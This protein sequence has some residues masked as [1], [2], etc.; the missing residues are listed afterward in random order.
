MIRTRPTT[1]GIEMRAARRC[2]SATLGLLAVPF[3]A[4]QGGPDELWNMTTRMEMAG[5]PGQS[6]SSQ[7]CMKKGQTQPDKMSQDKNCKATEM[8]TVG[9]KTTWKV[10]C[11]GREPMTGEGEVTRTRESMD[12][13]MRMQGK[14][15]N[16]T[17]DMTTVIS[18]RL[19]GACDAA[20]QSRQVQAAAAQGSAILAQQCKESMDK[21][22]TVMFD[23]QSAPCAAQ[24]AEYCGRVT[25]TAQ[26]MRK[27][28]GYRNAMKNE[29]LRGQGFEQAGQAC[30]VD[31][32]AVLG[33][34]CKSASSGRDWP[35]VADF[36]PEQAKAIAAE[37]CAGRKYTVAMSSEYKAVCQRYASGDSGGDANDASSAAAKS[38]SQQQDASGAPAAPSAADV[39]K[40]GANKLR[41]IFG[42]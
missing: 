38:Q 12:G 19:A 24:K 22:L 31:T 23:G 2:L 8:R 3:A 39:M 1:R 36:C 41:S 6:F 4:A 21:Y 37:H 5:M 33:D 10:V 27:P 28:A 35:F 40:E 42:R 11:S 34:A 29:G 13:R 15:G 18:G 30:S 17:F 32:A 16:E 14:S 26:S 20:Q 7:V 25:K 9:N